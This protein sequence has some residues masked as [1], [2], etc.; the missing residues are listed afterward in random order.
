MAEPRRFRVMRTPG[1][2]VLSVALLGQA[3]RSIG[4][5]EHSTVGS[6]CMI[7][8]ITEDFGQESIILK[9]VQRSVQF[10][11]IVSGFEIKHF[12]APP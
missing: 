6:S 3:P 5:S 2:Q 9:P 12:R 7:G 11:E 4:H 1:F 8:I 10:Q